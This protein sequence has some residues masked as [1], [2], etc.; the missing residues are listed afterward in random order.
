MFLT[1]TMPLGSLSIMPPDTGVQQ[2]LANSWV[3][4]FLDSVSEDHLGLAYL[5]EPKFLE[6]ICCHRTSPHLT[7]RI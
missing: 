3:M 7:S 1:W 2:K 4:Y 5:A 6:W